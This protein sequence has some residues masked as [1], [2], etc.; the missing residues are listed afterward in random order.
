[1]LNKLSNFSSPH[2]LLFPQVHTNTNTPTHKHIHTKKS[3]QRYTCSKKKKIEIH[4][5]T[6]TNKPKHTNN[7]ETDQCLTGTIRAY[8]SCLIRANG[9]RLIGAR[10]YGSCLIGAWSELGKSVLVDWSLIRAV[11]QCSCGSELWIGAVGRSCGS[12]QLWISAFDQSCGSELVTGAMDRCLSSEL[13]ID[14]SDQS[15]GSVLWIGACDQ[16]DMDHCLWLKGREM[17]M[18]YRE[19][20]REWE[21]WV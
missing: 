16:D 12:V 3:T 11:D 9:S 20:D 19:I 6:H 15:C 17:G 14:A 10:G 8:G 21:R 13:W 2:L 4:K 1:M 7:K 18:D 5:H